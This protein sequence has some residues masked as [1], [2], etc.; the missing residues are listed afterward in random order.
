MSKWLE[1]VD[2]G[3]VHVQINGEM[4]TYV[5]IL[6]GVLAKRGHHGFAATGEATTDAVCRYFKR[7][8]LIILDHAH[9]LQMRVIEQLTVFP[10]EHGIALA[11]IGNA[12]GYKALLDAKTKQI[13]S[14]VG[15]AMVHVNIP[16]AEDIDCIL[17]AEQIFGR[18]ER[19]FCHAIGCQ[20]GGLRYLY[21]TFREARKLHR[22]SGQEHLDVRFLKL[23]AAN[24]GCW[25]SAS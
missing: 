15:G 7:G 24:A 19:E 12:A 21:E 25:G 11:L 9:L 4:K 23:G 17:E 8:D 2:E 6:K 18:K 10:D 5:A 1:S 3:V 13:L 20:D 14:R 22:L 16:S